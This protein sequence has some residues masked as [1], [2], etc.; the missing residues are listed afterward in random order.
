MPP[1]PAY[2]KDLKQTPR[3]SKV[4]VILG[5]KEREGQGVKVLDL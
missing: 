2:T 3:L 4:A 5:W 1:D